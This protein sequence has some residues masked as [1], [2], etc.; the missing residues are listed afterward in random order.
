[1]ANAANIR[2]PY[3]SP[4]Q[5]YSNDDERYPIRSV[6]FSET[7]SQIHAGGSS[8]SVKNTLAIFELDTTTVIDDRFEYGE[9]R[10]QTLGLL[11]SRVILVVHT[12]SET[13]IR[14]IST[15][16]ATK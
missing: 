16:K 5:N 7:S 8:S 14:I 4:S 2:D 11:K 13:V 10:Y 6:G 15:R 9:T 3:P 1:M 12:K